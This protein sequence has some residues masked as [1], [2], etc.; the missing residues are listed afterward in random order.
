MHNSCMCDC[1]QSGVKFALQGFDSNELKRILVSKYT[2]GDGFLQALST[3]S[4]A[5]SDLEQYAFMPFGYDFKLSLPSAGKNFRITE[6]R[7][8]LRE[9]DKGGLT[10]ECEVCYND[11]YY[12]IEGVEKTTRACCS[13]DDYESAYIYIKK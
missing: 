3:D 10:N 12:R 11:I 2:A 9:E 1:R 6:I 13:G 5:A 4:F 8:G 7:Q